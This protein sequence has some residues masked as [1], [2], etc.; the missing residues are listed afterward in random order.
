[1][2]DQFIQRVQ[3]STG[4]FRI[5]QGEARSEDAK[6]F[7][8]ICNATYIRQVTEAYYLWQFFNTPNQAVCLFVEDK[9]QVVATYGLRQLTYTTSPNRFVGLTVDLIINPELRKSGLLARLEIELER[10]ALDLGCVC[11]YSLS[12]EAA[13][14]P[15]ISTLGWSSLGNRVTFITRTTQSAQSDTGISFHKVNR[16]EGDTVAIH[17]SFQETYP[18]LAMTQRT[19]RYLNWR[20]A[21]NPR[22]SYDLF[23]VR[24]HALFF[25]YLVLKVFRDPQTR[26][27][28]GDIVDLL[29]AEDDPDSLMAMLRFALSHFHAQGVKQATIWLQTHTLLD[30]VGRQLGFAETAQKRHFCCKVLD[31]RYRWLED[32]TRWFI[33]MADSEVY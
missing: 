14:K 8:A 18:S 3:E 4:H 10:S 22:Y 1:M 33:T 30:Q 20:F 28:V 17:R 7:A 12:N 21:D 29:W 9:G 11:L 24:R 13:Y 27:A 32:P 19:E 16:F 23:I 15:R 5:R 2:N 6:A 31:E 26:E 25:G